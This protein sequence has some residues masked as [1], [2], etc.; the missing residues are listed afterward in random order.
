MVGTS[1]S[2]YKILEKIGED[3][4]GEVYRATDT[5]LNRDV[6]LKILPEQFASDSQRMGR[7]QREAEVLASLDHPNIGQIY[8]IEEAGQTK[9]LV[10]Q[11]IEGPT[12]A[13]RIAQ[14]PIPVEDALKIALQI[15][16][17]LEAA[18]EKGVI[19]RD[20]K[21]ANIK[22]TPEGQVKI[23]DFGLA[24][25]LEG[26]APESSLSQSPTLT[27]AATQA[28][29]I[30][31]TAAYM[32]PEQARGKPV[33]KRVDVWAFGVVLYEM[34][35]GKHT[36]EGEDISL[37]LA[38][39]MKD[40]PRWEALPV[41]TPEAI[42]RLLRRCLQKDLDQRFRDIGYSRIEIEEALTAPTT[43]IP[44]AATTV[45]ARPSWR[46]AAPLVVAALIAG[47][48]LS[49]IT[50]WSLRS[51][52]VNGPLLH[53]TVALSEDEQLAGLGLMSPLAVSPNGSDIVYVATRDGTQQLFLRT[54]DSLEARPISGTE[55]GAGP[56]FSPDGQS[57]GFFAENQLKR[58]SIAGG[59]PTVLAPATNGRGGSWGSDGQI[60]Y[61]RRRGDDGLEQVSDSGGEPDLLTTPDSD[62]G[63]GAHRF[64]QHLPGGK[65]ILFTVGTGG[66][67]DDA[68]IVVQ[69]LDTGARKI[70]IE[71]G[72]DARYVRT[73][74][75]VYVRA[76]TLMVAPF[77]PDQLEVTGPPIAVV[78][79]VMPSRG[80]TGAAFV[81]FSELGWL[82]YVPG[83]AQAT[84]RK[85]AWV[86]REGKGQALPVAPQP[87]RIPSLSPD[88]QR[89]AVEID[90]GNQQDIW[91]YD[92]T[93]EA[94]TRLTFEGSNQSPAWTPDGRKVTFRSDRAGPHNLFW[95][96]GDGSG[97]T[98]RLT[99]SEQQQWESSWSPDG[100]FL[101]FYSDSSDSGYDIWFISLAGE[102]EPQLFLQ[103]EFNEQ[104]PKFSPDGRWLAY[105]SNES[106]RN[107]VY[108]RPFPKA[109]EGK[110]QISTEG[111]TLPVWARSGREL[112]YRGDNKMMAVDIETGSS[113]TPGKPRLL[114]D[115][116]PV[117]ASAT[118]DV[119]PD[120]QHFLMIQAGEQQ[121]KANQIHVITNWFEEL[122]R[123][124]PTDN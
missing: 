122:Q 81:G 36:F 62:K 124:A 92:I 83:T 27:N 107:E 80:I 108:V 24:K 59:R 37:T 93:R 104:F 38:A 5:K 94:L 77:D 79:G 119:T 82:A 54:L 67:W 61:A 31:G 106:G 39:V 95:K 45:S 76:G 97:A 23:L 111:G 109:E 16:E 118:F 2:H 42:R 35:T 88:G 13:E 117:D 99:T 116:T 9:A 29:V 69:R 96:S 112:F 113:L 25:A 123:L 75:L 34:L 6:A 26:D 89:V 46:Q 57:V 87:Y 60:I 121:E 68:L 18:H 14:G 51:S 10:L 47:A 64:P 55:G 72:S 86:D 85:L 71:G 3:G 66:S 19:H 98:E 74:H 50:A 53:L 70:L 73:G 114:F 115:V 41:R 32:S 21:P 101:A 17:G 1:I 78:E 15:A 105:V 100:Q 30:L 52:T 20:L 84:E 22:I 103:T 4:M 65:V 40:E 120:G 44:A 90:Q 8:G 7:F 12:L 49:A 11:L 91:V 28:R 102:R 58:V 110:W 33:D 43:E 56:F 63:E 48:I